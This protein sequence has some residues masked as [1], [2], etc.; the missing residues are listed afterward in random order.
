MIDIHAHVVLEQ[1]L[2]AAGEYGP[3]LVDADRCAGALPTFRVGDYELV[4][5]RYRNSAFM[6]LDVR[7]ALMDERGIELQVLSPNPLTYFAHIDAVSAAAEIRGFNKTAWFIVALAGPA[8]GVAYAAT[9]RIEN[10]FPFGMV[11]GATPL[12]M[13]I[14]L[15]LIKPPAANS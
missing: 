15:A 11:L 2:G 4:G 13:G 1:T 12:V 8:L 6:E 7:L 9:S 3:D 5:V 10:G 14:G